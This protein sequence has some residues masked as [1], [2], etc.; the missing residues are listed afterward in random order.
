M[1]EVNGVRDRGPG[2]A[3]SRLYA[4]LVTFRRPAELADTLSRLAEQDRPL[5]RLIV[6]D[7]FPTPVTEAIVGSAASAAASVE[8]VPAGENLGYTGGLAAGMGRVL[9]SA[10]DGDWIVCLDDDDPPTSTSTFRELHRFAEERRRVDP[11]TAGVAL[12]GARFDFRRGRVVRIPTE[13]LEG[14]V[15]LDYLGGNA[16]GCYLVSAIRAAGTFEPEIFFG[17]SEVEFGLRLRRAG[18]SLYGHGDLWRERRAAAGRSAH[19]MRP[20]WRVTE[21][22]WRQYY[23]LRNLIYILRAHGRR[24][25]AVRVTIAMGVAKP[26]ANLPFAPRAAV[27]SLALNAKAAVHGWRGFMGRRVEPVPWGPR[28]PAV[29]A[30]RERVAKVG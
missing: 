5:D 8:Y 19:E 10:G 23:S 21:P 24:G 30:G 7:N 29:P 26:V 2:V 11:R 16:F 22:N 9:D 25:A 15:S 27:R 4:V 13:T 20:A 17:F 18:Y 1:I 28:P 3:P 12:A 6:V 14:P